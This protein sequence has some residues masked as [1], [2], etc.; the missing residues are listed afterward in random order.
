[1]AECARFDASERK[2]LIVRLGGTRF[3]TSLGTCAEPTRWFRMSDST[4]YLMAHARRTIMQARRLPP[5]PTKFWLCH[6]GSVYHLLAKQSAYSNIEF[7][8]EYRLVKRAEEDL[9]PH[10]V[11]V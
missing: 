9:R 1:M 2:A 5:G 3:G 7:L 8:E 10:L 6:F 4:D 11:L